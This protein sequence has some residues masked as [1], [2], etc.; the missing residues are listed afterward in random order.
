[1]PL[2]YTNESLITDEIILNRGV[3]EEIRDLLQILV[4]GQGTGSSNA[5][6]LINEFMSNQDMDDNGLIYGFDFM[7]DE[8][9]TDIPPVVKQ[10]HDNPEWSDPV[11]VKTWTEY[12]NTLS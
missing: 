6:K 8:S 3:L 2:P 10:I 4:D 7:I 12:L 1:M 9:D 5:S 11:D